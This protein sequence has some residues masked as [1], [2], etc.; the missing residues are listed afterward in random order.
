MYSSFIYA[1]KHVFSQI[2]ILKPQS[3]T[4][5]TLRIVRVCWCSLRVSKLVRTDSSIIK[6]IF[7]LIARAENV[8]VLDEK[9]KIRSK[10]CTI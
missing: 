8:S 1:S 7:L 3:E 5:E 9:Q 4:Y 2:A 10:L 6:Q